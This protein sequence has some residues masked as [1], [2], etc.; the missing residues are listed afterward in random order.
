MTDD[1]VRKFYNENSYRYTSEDGKIL[2]F[3]EAKDRATIDL[4]IKRAKKGANRAYIAFK[5]GKIE[6]SERVEFDVNSDRF[7]RDI[8]SDIERRAIGDIL[9]PTGCR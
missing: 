6:K 4:K 1:E 2:S 3:D 7:S 8:W 9:K 5:K